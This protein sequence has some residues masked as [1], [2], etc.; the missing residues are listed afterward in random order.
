MV[1]MELQFEGADLDET[2]EA[3]TET[4]DPAPNVSEFIARI[5]G[6]L[7]ILARK[8]GKLS[9]DMEAVKTSSTSAGLELDE[10]SPSDLQNGPFQQLAMV[11]EMVR[12]AA[13]RTPRETKAAAIA[14]LA[15]EVQ[16]LA[17]TIDMRLQGLGNAVR[18]IDQSRITIEQHVIEIRR[19]HEAAIAVRETWALIALFAG[20]ALS[21]INL[22][23][24]ALFWFPGS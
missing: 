14:G 4:N 1:N 19:K 7:T 11:V 8:V 5:D 24:F 21:A 16:R 6:T 10:R 22:A 15:P 13:E 9:E 18:A 12:E 17:E 3:E 2:E 23:T 20:G